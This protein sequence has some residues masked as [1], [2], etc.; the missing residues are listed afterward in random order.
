M[1]NREKLMVLYIRKERLYILKNKKLR[2]EIIWL[3]HDIPVEGHRGQWKTVKL[4]T[5]NFWWPG[6]TKKVKQ[7]VEEYNTCQHNKNY[8]EQPAG[9]LMPNSIPEKPWTHII[10]RA[11][12]RKRFPMHLNT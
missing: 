9:K 7:Y 2:I 11:P 12:N 8:T 5:R 10:M 3:H 4:V 1:R 6:V